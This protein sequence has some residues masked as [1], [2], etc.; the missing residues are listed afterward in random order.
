MI[1]S[2][3]TRM[4]PLYLMATTLP[5]V[6]IGWVVRCMLAR[7]RPGRD[8]FLGGTLAR[9]GGGRCG[10]AVVD[11]EEAALLL[12]NGRGVGQ[13]R[14][15]RG[16]GRF[17]ERGDQAG[18]W[19]AAEALLKASNDH[20]NNSMEVR[21]SAGSLRMRL[22]AA[23]RHSCCS[24]PLTRTLLLSC[25]FCAGVGAMGCWPRSSG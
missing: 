16:L 12:R 15:R 2:A 7:F 4:P 8:E 9:L 14:R 1:V 10:R 5:P 25:L 18:A 22:H 13:G 3:A 23:V 19:Q 17:L 21:R 20:I 6:T 11:E 24:I